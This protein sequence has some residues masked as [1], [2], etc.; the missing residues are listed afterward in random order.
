[1]LTHLLLF[2]LVDFGTL[3]VTPTYFET[4]V[5]SFIIVHFTSAIR[6]LK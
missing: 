1:M 3:H 6:P 5:A 2:Q 4:I